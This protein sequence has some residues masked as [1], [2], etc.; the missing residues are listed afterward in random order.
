M[1]MLNRTF[2]FKYIWDISRLIDYLVTRSD[3]NASRIGI[4]GHSL[5]GQMAVWCA[6]YDSRIKVALSNCGIGKIQGNNSILGEGS[7][8]NYAFYMPSML[9]LNL[10]MEEIVGLIGNRSL[11]LSAGT[12]DY[13]LPVNG[14]AEI[15]N[16]LEEEYTYYNHHS[17][18]VTS[19]FVGGH[20]LPTI[21]KS[22]MYNF[23]D[24]QI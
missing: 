23:L 19:R 16:W 20:M 12:E 18:I 24:Q 6:V 7:F 14:V 9:K 11:F 8:Q 22:A 3:V 21:V 1:F 2:N 4:M 10:R 17:S 5:G 13:G 15:H